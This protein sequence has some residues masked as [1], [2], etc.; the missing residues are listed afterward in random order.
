MIDKYIK[1]YIKRN[2]RLAFVCA[3]I[4]AVPLFITSL[5]Y[6]V[7]AYDMLAALVPYPI[8]AVVVLFCSLPI[9]RFRRMIQKQEV[10]YGA[11]FNDVDV[12]HLETTLYISQD[13]LI[14]AGISAFHK[15]HIKQITHKLRHGRAGMSSNEVKIITVDNKKY[16]IWCLSTSNIKKVK[17]WLKTYL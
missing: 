8:A 13:W 14:W 17:D 4:V 15:R 9:F 3:T 6:D 5:F 2:V 10:L 1:I 11:E 7:L 12:K 16:T